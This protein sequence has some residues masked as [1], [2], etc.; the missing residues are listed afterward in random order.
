MAYV[1]VFEPFT[2]FPPE[3]PNTPATFLGATY[4]IDGTFFLITST[5]FVVNL[6]C[7]LALYPAYGNDVC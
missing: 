2:T 4:S 5:S 7:L 3:E 6:I 1:P